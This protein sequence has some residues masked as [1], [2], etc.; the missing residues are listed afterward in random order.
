MGRRWAALWRLQTMEELCFPLVATEGSVEGKVPQVGFLLRQLKYLSSVY[1]SSYKSQG[2]RC[3]QATDMRSQRIVYDQVTNPFNT[4]Y[5][6]WCIMS[7]S[8]F[9]TSLVQD[10][11]L[12]T[13]L[14]DFIQLR[15]V[16]IPGQFLSVEEE[17]SRCN[18]LSPWAGLEHL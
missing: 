11:L 14:Q 4:T 13:P 3:W 12:Y 7:H 10:L 1:I 16:L 6:L 18:I 9:P 8:E 5:P 2:Q 15:F 17:G